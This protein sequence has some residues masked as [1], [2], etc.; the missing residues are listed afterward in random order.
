MRRKRSFSSWRMMILP[1]SLMILRL[2]GSSMTRRLPPFST[3]SRRLFLKASNSFLERSARSSGFSIFFG[4]TPLTGA[5][6]PMPGFFGVPC[7]LREPLTGCPAGP[8]GFDRLGARGDG[9]GL[10]AGRCAGCPALRRARDGLLL[11]DQRLLSLRLLAGGLGPDVSLAL[12]RRRWR[13]FL[14]AGRGAW[15]CACWARSLEAVP[16]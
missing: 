16:S 6:G 4:G 14:A 5:S 12:I 10:A 13:D 15:R 7:A 1:P 8:R 2:P 9:W 11:L 3:V